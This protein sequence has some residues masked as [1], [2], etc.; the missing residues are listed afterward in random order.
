MQVG[1]TEMVAMIFLEN[2]FLG[3]FYRNDVAVMYLRYGI[4]IKSS[5]SG[6]FWV[7]HNL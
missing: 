5:K 7:L 4:K 2:K 6:V 3:I 1:D